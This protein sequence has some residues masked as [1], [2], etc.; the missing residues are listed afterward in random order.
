MSVNFEAD[1]LRRQDDNT[2]IREYQNALTFADSQVGAK[3]LADDVLRN[4]A[5]EEC[6][7]GTVTVDSQGITGG[8][9]QY[10]ISPLKDVARRWL[11]ARN[12]FTVALQPRM[13]DIQ[14][15]D[16]LNEQAEDII[17]DRDRKLVAID[18]ELRKNPKF[19]QADEHYRRSHQRFDDFRNKHG[20]RAA[21][22]FAK[23]LYYW[24]LLACVLATECF[25]NYHAFQEF[26]GVP[27]VALGTTIILGVLLALAAHGHGELLKQWSFRF[28]VQRDPAARMTDWRMLGMSTAALIIV[29]S[30]T[31]WARWAAAMSVMTSQAQTSLLGDVGMVQVNPMRDVFISLIANIGAW[32]V[33]VIVS[34]LGHDAD[35]DYADATRQYEKASR[36]WNSFQGAVLERRKHITASAENEFTNKKNA[37]TTRQAN[38]KAEYDMYQQI[39]LRH[40]QMRSNLQRLAEQDISRYRSALVSQIK[41]ARGAVKLSNEAGQPLSPFDYESMEL[42][43]PEIMTAE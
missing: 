23:R 42:I 12:N 35:P 6:S 32:M 26:W 20:N 9:R 2:L 1:G 29:L 41:S 10:V 43:T 8:M 30:F 24:L 28:G 16:E 27:A 22:M 18:E 11:V 37:A 40:G 7:F 39:R 38:V 21:V 34:Y 4:G 13:A 5:A 31:G 33:G 25:V 3:P 36:L 15:V 14:A 17:R 19:E